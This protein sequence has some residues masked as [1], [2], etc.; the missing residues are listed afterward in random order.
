MWRHFFE[1]IITRAGV[2]KPT[3]NEQNFGQKYHRYLQPT[4]VASDKEKK[5]KLWP[6][7]IWKPAKE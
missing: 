6:P 4:L 5:S 3:F 1:A 7:V 2:S